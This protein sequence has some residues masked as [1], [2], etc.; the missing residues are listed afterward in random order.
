MAQTLLQDQADQV[1]VTYGDMPLLRA[2]TMRRLAETQQVN[3]RGDR[4]AQR[5]WVI[6]DSTLWSRPAG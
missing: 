2:S 4:L 5:L 6:R 1:L 3:R